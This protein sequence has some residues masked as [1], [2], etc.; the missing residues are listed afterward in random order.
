[1]SD[2]PPV[3]PP[4]PDLQT[5]VDALEQKLNAEVA[6]THPLS[7]MF[8]RAR[9]AM[10][11]AWAALPTFDLK[12]V[13]LIVWMAV[14]T[15]AVFG[16]AISFNGCSLPS[17]P[18]VH[19]SPP[20]PL[21]GTGNRIL[22]VYD[23][24]SRMD[25]E[26]Q[27]ALWSEDVWRSAAANLAV[28]PEGASEARIFDQDADVSQEHAV[29]QEAMKKAKG[30]KLP[31]VAISGAKANF[32]G[33]LPKGKAEML[34]LLKKCFGD[35]KAPPVRGPPPSDYV[36][37]DENTVKVKSHGTG[38]ANSRKPMRSAVVSDFD[39]PEMTDT[40]IEAAIIRK[41]ADKSW[42]DDIR[43]RGNKGNPIP[44]RDQNGKGYCW[45][46]SSVSA[47][48][49][50]R[51]S[52][53]QPYSDLSAFA[54]ACIIKGYR[55]EGGWGQESLDFIAKRGVPS[56]TFWPQRSMSPSNDKPETWENAKLHRVTEWMQP[57]T[58]RQFATCLCNN[59]PVVSDYNF[60]SHSV[61]DCRL[62]AWGANG[63]NLKIRLWNSW[64]DGWSANGMGDLD[65]SKAMPDDMVAPRVTTAAFA[66]KKNSEPL[67]AQAP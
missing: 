9:T 46:H 63:A 54:V 59:I 24:G 33:D 55:D 14:I 16:S 12:T 17:I 29:W 34:A 4:T 65:S 38:L 64:G 27:S 57:K 2:V 10:G 49:L 61:C 18:W 28:G 31:Y 51:A 23:A 3:V 66:A 25:P 50:V 48:L 8:P 41:N 62:L 22:V 53:N 19:P 13:G 21:P 36:L 56:A 35:A 15:V 43:N 30:K 6:H 1:M 11:R 20:S 37:T 58:K 45:A 7:R 5:R 52:N 44:S 40:E 60:W 42:L 47:T 39:L 67:Y 26:A 32:D